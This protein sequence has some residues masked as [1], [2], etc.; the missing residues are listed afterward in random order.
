MIGLSGADL[1][2]R[3]AARVSRG[4]LR[5]TSRLAR[6][7]RHAAAVVAG[8]AVSVASTVNRA[9][10]VEVTRAGADAQRGLSAFVALGT[11]GVELAWLGG[12][13]VVHAVVLALSVDLHAAAVTDG[14]AVGVRLAL[15]IAFA[16]EARE[17]VR[18]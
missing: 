2:S 14:H 3:R 13:F 17:A 18:F 6:R 16:L 12:S 11:A 5:V 7:A 4:C 10:G 8:S 1:V 9:I 15:V